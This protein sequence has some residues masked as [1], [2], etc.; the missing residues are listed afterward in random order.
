MMNQQ[1]MLA[2]NGKLAENKEAICLFNNR[3]K[4]S[5]CQRTFRTNK[6]KQQVAMAAQQKRL[7]QKQASQQQP[8]KQHQSEKQVQ[9]MSENGRKL[10]EIEAETRELNQRLPKDE[11]LREKRKL[12]WTPERLWKLEK[13]KRELA[14]L[15]KSE[16]RNLHRRSRAEYKL[17]TCTKYAIS[18][19]RTIFQEHSVGAN[20]RK[21]SM[22][23]VGTLLLLTLVASGLGH[24]SL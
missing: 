20:Q 16:S 18:T 14:L 12:V 15:N 13:N 11:R 5:N 6:R 17:S 9:P 1:Q 7:K 21:S 8:L 4:K 19:G 22:D 10:G 24:W 3:R 2:N 23:W